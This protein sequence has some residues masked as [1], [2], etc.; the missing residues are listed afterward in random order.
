MEPPLRCITSARA[1]EQDAEQSDTETIP[2]CPE[3]HRGATG[4]H[5]M[6]RKAFERAYGVTELELLAETRAMIGGGK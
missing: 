1:P 5:G 3:H 6:G 2:L 4:L